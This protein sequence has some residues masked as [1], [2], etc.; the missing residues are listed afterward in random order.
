MLSTRL[1][2]V[3]AEHNSTINHQRQEARPHQARVVRL[4]PLA[5][6]P[7]QFKLSADVQGAAWT[8]ESYIADLCR[9]V[10][11]IGSTPMHHSW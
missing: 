9:P 5:S 3:C 1:V 2:A 4:P 10:T 8:G 6:R 7:V 11:S